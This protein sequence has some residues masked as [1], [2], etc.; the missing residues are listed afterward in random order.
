MA[1]EGFGSNSDGIAFLVA[2]Y[3]VYEVIAGAC[4]SPQTTEINAGARAE[5]L[6]KWVHLG[7]A[8]AWVLALVAAYIDR[9]HTKPILAGAS[10]ATAM[11]YLSYI[12][13][14]RAGLRNG[15]PPTETYAARPGWRLG[16]A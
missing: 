16:P 7:V 11:Q 15:G 1:A 10:V 4:S 6:M 2:A 12:H 14:K 5:T 13:A 9:K 8:Q 3:G